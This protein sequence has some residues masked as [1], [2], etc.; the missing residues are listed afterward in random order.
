MK[1]F[2]LPSGGE[3]KKFDVKDAETY[4]LP[5]DKL[6]DILKTDLTKGL[7][8]KEAEE[9]LQIA[10]PN[11]IPKVKPSFYKLWIAPFMN[12]LITIYLI[13]SAVLAV[14]AFFILP[15]AGARLFIWFPAIIINAAVSILQQARAQKKLEALL[16]LSAPK[17]EVIRDG[18]TIEMPS[19][20]LVPGDIVKLDRGDRIPADARIISA[21]GLR[22]NEAALTGESE[23]VEK[24]ERDMT[25]KQDTPI[26]Q[27]ENMLFLGTYVTVGSGKALIVQTG[28]QTQIGRISTSLQA[29]DTGEIPLRKKINKLAK[30]L[31][32]AVML[33]IIVSLTYQILNLYSSDLLFTA[34][35]LNTKLVAETI[36]GTLVTSMSIMPINIPVLTTI[37]LLIGI[38]AMVKYQVVIRDLNAVESLGRVSV[39][40]SDKTGTIT[41]NEMT[42]KWVSF[43]S[44]NGRDPT[45]C[46]SGV[47]FE[48]SGKIAAIDSNADLEEIVRTGQEVTSGKEPE[49]EPDT[50]LEY[51]MISSVLDNESRVVEEKVKIGDRVRTVFKASGNVTDAS[52][53]VL[54]RKSKLSE[55]G[56][57]ARFKQARTYAFDSRLKRTTRIFKDSKHGKYILLTKGATEV[58]LPQ[59]SSIAKERITETDH[60]GRDEKALLDKKADLFASS[61]YRVISFAFRYLDE[62]PARGENER[63]SVECDLTYL[64][65]VA[66]MDPPREGVYESVCEARDA[67]IKSVMITGDNLETARSIAQQVGIAEKSDLAIEGSKV[68]S[69]SGREFLKTSVFARVSPENK[70][71]IVDRYKK[72]D[73]VVAMTGD[74][75]NDALAISKADVGIAT[76]ITGTD[77]AKQASGMVITDDSFN[78]IVAGIRE[79]RGLFQKIRSIIFFYIA[80]NLAEALLYFGSSLIPRFTLLNTWQLIY[81]FATV[82]AIPPMAIVVGHTSKDVMKEKPRD[83][84]GIFNKQVGIALT[85]FAISLTFMFYIVYYETLNGTIPVFAENITSIIVPGPMPGNPLNPTGW[86]HAKARTMFHSV[87]VVAECTL[88]FSL[89]QMNKPIHATMKDKNYRIFWPFVLS[90]PIAHLLLMYVPLI[91]RLLVQLLGINFEIVPLTVIDWLI[92]IAAGLFPV[93][94]LELYKVYVRKRRLC[95]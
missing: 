82:H 2:S 49:I 83:S 46:V 17:C 18:K 37:V 74:G 14:F 36:V 87:L 21:S 26:H 4:T 51:I 84:E 86:E 19:E 22:V 20:Q 78:S 92:V 67:G 41:K 11:L 79:G 7:S 6:S 56:Y 34:G 72:Q 32:F 47:G 27:R 10:G 81:V 73:R 66:I 28:K 80:V 30:Y 42:A 50:S 88:V 31:G 33:Y 52:L 5:L 44:I 95:F 60:I 38:I 45:Y 29:L 62:L 53:L 16:R 40:C 91:Q 76:G 64:G 93:L 3:E 23:E 24:L 15:E 69:L 65:F 94:L 61:G 85:I 13:I 55:K 9:R 71:T 8:V 70:M 59:C 90:I 43:P 58:L 12:L 57:R 25:L 75:V 89:A 68:E 1:A 63:K 54:F 39:V 48:P 35:V 77:V